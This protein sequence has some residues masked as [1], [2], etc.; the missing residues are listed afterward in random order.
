MAIL[1]L[2]RI[3]DAQ[4][5]Y[6]G[7]SYGYSYTPQRIKKKHKLVLGDNFFSFVH[8]TVTCSDFQSLHVICLF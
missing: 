1:K 6:Y 5:S 3:Y 4:V 8:A 2:E 7:Y